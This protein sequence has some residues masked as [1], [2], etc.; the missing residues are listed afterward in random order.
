[1]ENIGD[2]TSKSDVRVIICFLHLEG[3]PGNNTHRWLCNVFGEES[4]MSKRAVYQWIQQFD[5]QYSFQV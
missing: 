5:A 4:I 1:M 3:V 2:A